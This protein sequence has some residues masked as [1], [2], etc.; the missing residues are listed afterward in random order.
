MRIRILLMLAVMAFSLR[1]E[2]APE[3]IT[4]NI[5]DNV[6]VKDCVRF[7]MNLSGDNY[8]SGMAQLKLRV[9]ENFEGSYYRQ[10]HAGP[11]YTADY[12]ISST[13]AFTT[14]TGWYKLLKGAD[15][16]VISGPAKWQKGKIKELE[17]FEGIREDGKTAKLMK[18][19]FESPLNL[20]TGTVYKHDVKGWLIGKG[21]DSGNK[22]DIPA[23]LVENLNATNEGFYG[24]GSFNTGD[25]GSKALI[26][27]VSPDSFG[28]AAL[29]L[30]GEGK[31]ATVRFPCHAPRMGA[32][33]G[34]WTVRFKAK[35][36]DGDPK[37]TFSYDKKTATLVELKSGW[38]QFEFKPK[39]SGATATGANSEFF[40]WEFAVTGGSVLLDDVEIVMD[41]LG[42]NPT[43]FSDTA[44]HALKEMN[45]GIVR[46]VK[47]GGD[48]MENFIR[49]P[50]QKYRSQN[51][52]FDPVGPNGKRNLPKWGMH[53]LFVMCEY[54]GASPW[55][56]LP[57]TTT[58][59]E[60]DF[61][62]E[63]LS[64]PT[65]TPGG[66]LRC[67]LGH[68]KPWT[69][70]LSQIYLE[71][72]NESWNTMLGFK[73]GGFNG[74]DYWRDLF[75]RVKKSP[76][77][78]PN[79]L[80]VP[81]GQN[82]QANMSYRVLDGMQGLADRYA[83]GPYVHHDLFKEQWAW[84]D[85]DEK[86]L[87]WMIAEPFEVQKDQMPKQ[88]EVS[89]KFG[90]EFAIYEVN[91]HI[92]G[93]DAPL[94]IRNKLMT[95]LAGGVH[96]NNHMLM[97]LKNYGVRSQCMFTFIQD[98]YNAEGI[99]PC[100]LWGTVMA[101]PQTGFRYRPTGMGMK[102]VNTV[103][104]GDL[105]ETR[106]S[107]SGL[108][109]TAE[110]PELSKEKKKLKPKA[111]PGEPKKTGKEEDPVLTPEERAE[112]VAMLDFHKVE[113]PVITS[114]AFKDGDKQS[115]ILCNFDLS[116]FRTVEIK[117]NGSAGKAVSYLM[118]AASPVANNE[119]EHEEQVSI[120]ETPLD[121]FK[122]GT[123]VVIPPCSMMGIKW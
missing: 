22:G 109:Y 66:K 31:N 72:G 6:L 51:S 106:Q 101:D 50:L 119:W 81:A 91:H 7:G 30:S 87:Q 11:E 94:G 49:P 95:S 90:V 13:A 123:Q 34:A 46:Q 41:S 96:I 58:R 115:L 88:G 1:A 8:Y 9:A 5:T 120:K 60:A 38:K 76:Y 75:E 61:L 85:T 114:Y 68:P 62:M 110:V 29:L 104:A 122:S 24:A 80:T 93:G 56:C 23:I 35:A 100:R 63:Y 57:G 78:K 92:T 14:N 54:I 118:S 99:G 116:N 59:E 48:T 79:V 44:L 105:V 121:G 16:T 74:P 112:M 12:F 84:M 98:T 103:M 43:V 2:K 19:F 97:M 67:E 40:G 77:Y 71:I 28:C 17:V 102:L 45:V 52:V 108:T 37:L 64:G 4:V 55:F 82:Y 27:D 69:E 21:G 18:I 26:G 15:F 53:D 39:V 33:N 32:V 89:K 117:F 65:T 86:A 70:T 25:S 111:K 113:I 107:G 20:P 10:C 47:M 73:A 36:K 42:T 83:Y 3:V